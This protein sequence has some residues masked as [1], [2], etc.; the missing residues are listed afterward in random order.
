ME[1]KKCR[2]TFATPG[3]CPTVTQKVTEFFRAHFTPIIA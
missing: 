1:N 3:I 2:K